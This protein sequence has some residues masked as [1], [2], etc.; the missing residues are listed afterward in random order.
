MPTFFNPINSCLISEFSATGASNST[1]EAQLS[2]L[3]GMVLFL[4]PALGPTLGG[5]L[6][7]SFGWQSIFLINV[8]IGVASG[9]TVLTYKHVLDEK[10]E[11]SKSIG[12][13]VLGS[14]LLSLGLV[15]AIYGASEGSLIG[16]L[17][18]LTLPFLV[19]GLSL[20]AIYAAWALNRSYPAVNIKLLSLP[21]RP[22]S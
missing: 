5:F 8:P 2:P 11:A 7:G 17:S 9:L 19:G 18:I 3:L 1:S 12:F 6:I 14:V 21:D 4:A 15:L 10:N 16:W 13:D 22:S 20:M